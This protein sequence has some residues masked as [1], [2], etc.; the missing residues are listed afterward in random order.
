MLSVLL[1]SIRPNLIKDVITN[2]LEAS[3]RDLEIIIVADHLPIFQLNSKVKW[4]TQERGGTVPA[5]N[6]A[7]QMSQGEYI[8]L[9][10]DESVIQ[11]NG[12]DVLE[13]FAKDKIALITPKHLPFFPFYYYHK[14]F[15]AFPFV[16]RKDLKQITGGEFFFN[17]ELHSFYAD[18]DQSMR[19]W[20]KNIPVIECDKV[21][22]QHTNNWSREDTQS[23][24]KNYF[25]LDREIF[26]KR[27]DYLGPFNDP[28]LGME[29]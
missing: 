1:P 18:P 16:N 22:L 10:N 15:A 11:K 2:L 13:D 4:Y 9:M 19:A 8:F 12:L 14:L 21:I 24:I 23:N 25:Q 28:F 7:Y 6:L 20:E 29:L 26:R 27:W 5:I 3:Q 17:P